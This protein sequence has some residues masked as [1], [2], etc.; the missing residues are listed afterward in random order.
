MMSDYAVINPATG[1]Q[2]KTYP[3]ITDDELDRAI[4]LAYQTHQGWLRSTTVEERAALVRRVGE[5]HT[6]RREELAAITVRE[7]GKPTERHWARSTFAPT[8]TG[9]TQTTG[10]T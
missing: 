7:M 6:E 4:G 5:L 1:E 10:R 2:L 8:S 9:T 3:T